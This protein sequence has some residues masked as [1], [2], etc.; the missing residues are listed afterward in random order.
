MVALSEAEWQYGDERISGER[1]LDVAQMS[2]ELLPQPVLV[3]DFS[4]LTPTQRRLWMRDI[5]IAA[6]CTPEHRR[7]VEGTRQEFLRR[8]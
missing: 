4:A 7:C 6:K 1:L 5:A 2:A 8:I 3:V